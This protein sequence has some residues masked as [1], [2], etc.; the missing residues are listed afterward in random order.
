MRLS[1]N[2]RNLITGFEGLSLKAYPD[3]PLPKVNGQWAPNQ[4]WSIGYGHQLG[5]G[6]YEGTT[7]TREQ[8]QRY[9]DSDVAKYEAAVSLTTPT[10]NQDQFDAFTSLA[11]NIGTAGFASSTAAKRHNMGDFA[12]AAEAIKMWNKAAG[13]VHPGLVK[14]REREASIYLYGHG[15]SPYP[16]PGSSTAP[17][18]APAYTAQPFPL[19]PP[20]P[21][22]PGEIAGKGAAMLIAGV[23]MVF[24]CPGCFARLRSVGV[25]VGTEKE[26]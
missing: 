22:L 24:F 23:G 26:L 3:P 5:K 6:N 15:G 8:A 9:F 14:R 20:A 16:T 2:G 19:I 1:T 13:A 21:A 18:P 25:E 7:I 12:G 17:A 10:A 11:Y 4:L